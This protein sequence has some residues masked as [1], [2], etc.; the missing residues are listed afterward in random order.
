MA[1]FVI[2]GIVTLVTFYIA[3]IYASTAIGLLGFAEAVLLVLAFV[4]LLFQRSRI[5]VMLRIPIG[6]AEQGGRVQVQIGTVNR[7][8]IPCMRIRYRVRMWNTLQKKHGSVWHSGAMV[9]PGENS[10]QT[11]VCP[12]YAGNY[13][14]ELRSVKLYDLTGLFYLTKRIKSSAGIQVLPEVAPVSVRV[15]E[16]TRNFFGDADVYDDFRPGNDSSEI[17]DVR[18]FRDGDKIQSIHWKLSAKMQELVVREDS[19]PL[20]CPVVLL[21]DSAK[22]RTGKQAQAFLSVAAS[23]VFSMMDVH[24]PHYVSWYSGSQQDMVRV[25][26]DDEEGYYTFLSSY[27]ADMREAPQEIRQLYREKY[28]YDHELHTLLL[29]GELALSMDGK[30]LK[31]LSEVEWKERLS[32]LELIL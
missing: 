16:R 19:Q 20:A 13:L 14:V 5:R 32:A 8:P 6:V 17:F 23:L 22:I 25:R 7:G 15:T 11:V 4:F 28:R 29:T 31:K 26:V 27:L 1:S 21:L 18:E 24:C 9:Y 30:L 2:G 10:Y 12:Q 3:L